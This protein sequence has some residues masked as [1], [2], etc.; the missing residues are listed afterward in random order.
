[1]LTAIATS[2]ELARFCALLFFRGGGRGI[3]LF[4]LLLLLAIVGLLVW[5]YS[6]SG[7]GES[8]GKGD[9]EKI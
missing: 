5:A 9:S 6:S 1:M 4:S 3:E 2:F 7:N 8:A